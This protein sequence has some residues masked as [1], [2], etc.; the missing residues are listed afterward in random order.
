MGIAKNN[1]ISSVQKRMILGVV[2]GIII[3]VVVFFF[4]MQGFQNS[5]GPSVEVV[6]KNLREGYTDSDYTG[7]VDVRIYNHGNSPIT[8]TV[9][10]EVSQADVGTWTKFQTVFLNS[11]EGKNLTFEFREIKSTDE[12][13]ISIISYDVWVTY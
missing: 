1:T 12:I 8:V 4:I 5:Q 3:L 10:A 11:K 13:A 2:V 6:Y 7:W 9:Y